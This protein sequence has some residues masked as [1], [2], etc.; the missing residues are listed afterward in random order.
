[1]KSQPIAKAALILAVGCVIAYYHF[2]LIAE[3]TPMHSLH[4]RLN[5]IP[6]LLAA[7][8]FGRRGG[9]VAA[10]VLTSIYLP[11][12]VFGHGA[13]PH[14]S[15]LNVYMEFILYNVMGWLVG[16]LVTRR[17]RDQANLGEARR[18]AS[19]GQWAA[20]VAHE[21]RNPAQTIQS[22]MDV[23]ARRVKDDETREIVETVKEEAARLGRFAADFLAAGRPPTPRYVAT[24]LEELCR[25]VADRLPAPVR[26][27]GLSIEIVPPQE[28]IEAECD[29]EQLT[30]VVRNLIENAVQAAGS[31]GHVRV[32]FAR[33]AAT[34]AIL[35]EDSGPGVAAR[36]R[37]EIFEPFVSRRPG[38]TGL[39]LAV[40]GRIVEAHGGRITC[41]ISTALGGA[42]FAIRLPRRR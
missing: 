32:S 20:G 31:A 25:R 10:A 12:V 39:G 23:L 37:D 17:V 42:L 21:I 26:P 1:M 33:D 40:A 29:P 35:V 41:A 34:A 4:Y 5:Y 14:E 15:Q 22:A 36:M 19:L 13:N 11:H 24:D 28:R 27:P 7:I 2:Q 18:L 3:A 9:I 6:I 16:E 8:W 38:G 30:Q